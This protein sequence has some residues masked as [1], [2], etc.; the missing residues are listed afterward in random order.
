MRDTLGKALGWVA[1]QLAQRD[2]L[3]GDTFTLADAYLFT[4]SG[5]A[6]V[7]GI[8]LPERLQ[9]YRQTLMQ[10]DSIHQALKAEGLL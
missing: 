4:V 5:W 7:A 10:R 3:T 2:F 6:D 8:T 1:Q 9:T